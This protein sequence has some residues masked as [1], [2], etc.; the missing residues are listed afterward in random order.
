M[1]Q[2]R[3]HKVLLSHR[4]TVPKIREGSVPFKA[5]IRLN[6]LL[7]LLGDQRR[8]RC[9]RPRLLNSLGCLCV[10][11]GSDVLAAGHLGASLTRLP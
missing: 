7:A 10:Q 1:E 3:A 2:G 4:A 5:G 9:L 11:S 8:L 6:L